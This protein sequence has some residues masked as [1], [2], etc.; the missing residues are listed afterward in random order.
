M[1]WLLDT[2]VISEATR[3]VPS[4]EVLAWV[5]DQ[6]LETLCTLTLA[7]AEIRAGIA[8]VAD[9]KRKDELDVWLRHKVRPF[10]G[11]RALEVDEPRGWSCCG[12]SDARK[13][14]GERCQLSI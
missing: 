3:K 5:G 14:P 9:P 8:L 6:K 11:S 4:P 7:F 13:P 2:N 10:F 12:F 1:K